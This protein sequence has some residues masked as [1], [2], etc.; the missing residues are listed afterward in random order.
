MYIEPYHEIMGVK[1]MKDSRSKIVSNNCSSFYC[2]VG[3]QKWWKLAQE[4]QNLWL[5]NLSA[6]NQAELSRYT[7]GIISLH[8]ADFST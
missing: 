3:S 5:K 4:I 1:N 6:Q 7:D 8:F 2:E